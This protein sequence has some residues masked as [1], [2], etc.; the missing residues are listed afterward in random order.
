MYDGLNIP[1]TG[2]AITRRDSGRVAA[3][4]GGIVF[5]LCVG[6]LAFRAQF[7]IARTTVFTE[8]VSSIRILKTHGTFTTLVNHMG[9]NAIF[10]GAPWTIRKVFSL[11]RHEMTIVFFPNGTMAYIID[12]PLSDD[13]QKQAATYGR[14]IIVNKKSTIITSQNAI[15]TANSLSIAPSS[16][17]PWHQGEVHDGDRKGAVTLDGRGIT[18]KHIG[19]AMETTQPM[20]ADETTVSAY[21]T[22][23]PGE[24]LVPTALQSL[25]SSPISTIFDLFTENGGTLL[26]THDALGDGY[27]LTTTPGS[28]TSEDLAAMGKDIINRGLL[29]TQAWTLEDGST[30]QEVVGA[31]DSLSV[32]ILAEEDFTYVSLK[33]ANGNTLRMTKAPDSLTIANREILITGGV[34]VRSACIPNA[35][36][37]IALDDFVQNAN[38]TTTNTDATSVFIKLF[39]EIAVSNSKVRMC[40]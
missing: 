22:T 34:K 25:M 8:S 15:I 9:N 31:S 30:Y 38:A 40:W 10:P 26:L 37:W 3:L 16:L 5:G 17:F 19:L 18:L 27:V 36:S 33:S 4:V 7:V 29:S 39:S 24:I 21:L 28:L 20:A 2:S 14:Q 12:A 11:S 13:L 35:H 1:L 32:D 23:I 6:I